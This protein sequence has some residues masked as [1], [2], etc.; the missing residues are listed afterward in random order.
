MPCRLLPDV[1][2]ETRLW[3]L[4][5]IEKRNEFVAL[6]RSSS[7]LSL[8]LMLTRSWRLTSGSALRGRISTSKGAYM[9]RTLLPGTPYPLG[10]KVSSKGTN[11]AV[12]SECATGVSVCLF[13]ES[14][15]QTDCI[16]LR[17]RTAFI[18]HGLIKGVKAGQVY[19]FRVE[20]PW[21]PEKGLRF[22]P[23]KLLVDPYAKAISG[24]VDW[25][26]PVF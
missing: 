17:E 4:H 20:G 11:F 15:K 24:A 22:N 26:S 6:C 3:K 16:P 13:D 2:R 18:W 8:R 5:P 21:E 23:S 25:K 14:G 19:G 1:S 9:Q 10:A 7:I 12:Y